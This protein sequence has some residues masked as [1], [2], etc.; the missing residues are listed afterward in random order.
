MSNLNLNIVRNIPLP[1]PSLEEQIKIVKQVENLF[2][3]ADK[4]EVRY[5]KAKTMLDKLP[6]SILAKAFRGELV[7]Q[8]P[9]DEPASVLLERIKKEKDKISADKKGKKTKNT[10]LRKTLKIAEKE[11]KYKK[12]MV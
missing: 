8:D 4:I 10:P 9:N 11:V 1:L 7:A 5:T 2:A 3:F 12:A 6:Q